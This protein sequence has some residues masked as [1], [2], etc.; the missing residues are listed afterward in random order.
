MSVLVVV[1]ALL[2]AAACVPTAAGMTAMG[3]A[4]GDGEPKS[5]W[6]GALGAVVGFGSVYY[7]LVSFAA[8]W[9]L[10]G[11][12]WWPMWAAPV[13]GLLGILTVRDPEPDDTTVTDWTVGVAMQL[14]VAVPPALLL[15]S[16]RVSI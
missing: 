1:L 16:A 8:F 11:W 6:A 14:A 5:R 13:A 15:L 4:G 2:I 12:R 3:L 10:D 7:V 9:D